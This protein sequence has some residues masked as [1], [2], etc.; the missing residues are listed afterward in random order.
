MGDSLIAIKG[1]DY[2]LVA[3][4]SGAARFILKMKENEDKIVAL[5][6]SKLLAGSGPV[7]DRVQFSEYI[8]KNIKLYQF[9][10][11]VPLSTHA[12]A[13]YMRSELADALRTAPYQVNLLLA[14]FDQKKGPSLFWL[15]YLAALQEL[16]CGSQGY[17]AY[18]VSSILDKHY[19]KDMD[20]AEGLELL[21]LCFKELKTRFIMNTNSWFVKVVDKDGVRRVVDVEENG[22]EVESNESKGKEKERMDVH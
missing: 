1:K 6:N 19:H 22:D 12:A 7:G 9:R 4:D 10:N 18:F 21:R 16:D 17:A 20:Y 3:A 11:N 15:D 5:D 2:V 14:G 13:N 8:Q